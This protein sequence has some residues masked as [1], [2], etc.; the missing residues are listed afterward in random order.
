MP[1]TEMLY[2]GT[3]LTASGLLNLYQNLYPDCTKWAELLA[4]KHIKGK[5]KLH[6]YSS[7]FIVHIY[8]S[9]KI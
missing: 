4:K 1:T 8:S 6:I 9:I 7:I 2:L 5:P 3:L